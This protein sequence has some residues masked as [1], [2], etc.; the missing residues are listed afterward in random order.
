MSSDYCFVKFT[1]NGKDQGIAYR[2][3]KP[4][5]KVAFGAKLGHKIA[6][7]LCEVYMSLFNLL[8]NTFFEKLNR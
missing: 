6:I 8:L 3:Q 4:D 5:L 7:F 2:F 1:V